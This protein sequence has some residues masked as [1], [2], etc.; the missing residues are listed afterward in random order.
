[1]SDYSGSDAE[2]E[3]EFEVD[4]GPSQG[5]N[6]DLATQE[7]L[8]ETN[9]TRVLQMKPSSTGEYALTVMDFVDYLCIDLEL[10]PELTW[11]AR[12]MCN[13]P[14]PPNAEMIISRNTK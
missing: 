12:E 6:L 9:A 14:M 11:I 1:M 5:T 3:E 10:E 13:A 4:Q 7:F 8:D 2:S